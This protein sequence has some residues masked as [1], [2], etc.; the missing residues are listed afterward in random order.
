MDKA[1]WLVGLWETQLVHDPSYLLSVILVPSL[2]AS[3]LRGE[4]GAKYTR[5]FQNDMELMVLVGKM[6][7]R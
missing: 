3:I 7:K 5:S 1:C 4:I 6:Q 2:G